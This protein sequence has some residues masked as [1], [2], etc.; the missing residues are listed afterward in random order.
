MTMTEAERTEHMKRLGL[1]PEG[2]KA[3]PVVVAPV[4]ANVAA[5]PAVAPGVDP[6][7]MNVDDIVFDASLLDQFA[8]LAFSAGGRAAYDLLFQMYKSPPRTNKP[9]NSLLGRR[10][11]SFISAVREARLAG[12]E[13]PVTDR[14]VATKQQRDHAAVLAH[15][16]AD[17]ADV[18]EA[19]R[20]RAALQAAGIDIN[21]LLNTEA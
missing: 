12:V 17:A 18:A 8:D 20:I 11:S 14:I 4:A 3:A 16:D 7:T 9:R 1:N 2:A 19:L 21:S 5:A 10:I 15:H 6:H 13:T